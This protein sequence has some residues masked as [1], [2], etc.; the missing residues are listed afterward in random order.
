MQLANI[1]ISNVL[2]YPYH[3]DLRKVEGVRFYNREDVNVNVL[4]GPNGA[5]KS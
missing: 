5:G 2:S 1:K 4:I 3:P